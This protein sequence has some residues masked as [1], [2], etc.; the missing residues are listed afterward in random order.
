ML[1]LIF[2]QKSYNSCKTTLHNTIG[3]MDFQRKLQ[4]H[5]WGTSIQH[6]INKISIQCNMNNVEFK[7][8][9]FNGFAIGIPPVAWQLVVTVIYWPRVEIFKQMSSES[10]YITFGIN[11]IFWNL[12]N[13]CV[14]NCQNFLKLKNILRLPLSNFQIII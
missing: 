12:S 5:N 10:D 6:T 1:L 9:D 3:L 14:E 8:N 2:A 13:F 7:F 4:L 11:N